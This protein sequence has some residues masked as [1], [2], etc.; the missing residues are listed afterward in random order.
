MHAT[1]QQAE[2][3][4]LSIYLSVCMS[5]MEAKLEGIVMV[6]CVILIK[7]CACTLCTGHILWYLCNTGAVL[8]YTFIAM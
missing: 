2:S 5:D 3:V 7:H 4:N 8:H 1:F 6:R